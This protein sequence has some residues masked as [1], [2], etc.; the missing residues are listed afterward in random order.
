[1]KVVDEQVNEGFKMTELG[2]LPEDWK[3]VR[4]GKII[5][6]IR[7]GLVKSQNKIFRGIPIT[8]IE[9]IA[10]ECIDTMRLGYIEGVTDT[11]IE[12]YRLRDGDILFSHINS[13]SQIGKSAIY[14]STLPLILH[15][16]NL[17][18]IRVNRN[19]CDA[20]YL[21]MLFKLYRAKGSFVALASRAVG[22]ASVNQGRLRALEILLP[23]LPEQ[24]KIAAVLS[25]VQEAR[26]KTEDVI[27]ATRELKKSLM[28]HLF[29]YGPVPLNEAENVPLKETEIGMIPEHWEVVQIGEIAA[30]QGGYAFKS[31]DYIHEGVPLFKISNVSFGKVIWD[32][33]S[34]LPVD[35]IKTHTNYLLKQGDLVM[36]MTRPIVSEG[37][38]VAR[39][40][41]QDVPC[42][43]NQRV[44]R[45][46]PKD[47]IIVEF[48]FQLLFNRHFIVLISDGALGSQQPNISANK[49]E[50]IQI[51][52]P[53]LPEQQ[54]IAQILSAVDEKI[55][56]EEN[57]RKA[58]EGLFKSLLSNLMTG[59]IRTKNLEV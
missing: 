50:N 44:C 15:G 45:F 10:H 4:L 59:K 6:L 40:S 55:E 35:Y 3:V 37:I 30:V 26:E 42:L 13:E 39:V 31:K 28:K 48:L 57:K 41:E 19:K 49:I 23:P 14:N 47:K 25:A 53:P 56:A 33:I 2:L 22:Q 7:N 29:T 1:M 18:L 51:P 12:Q 32:D 46:K 58:L 54:Q 38:K 52:L 11:E 5:N 9:T 27:K 21:N 20:V 24:Q 16:M 34:F 17:L 36:A 8:R 43:L